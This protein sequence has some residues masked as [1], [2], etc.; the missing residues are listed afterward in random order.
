MSSPILGSRSRA[1][2]KERLDDLENQFI[3]LRQGLLDEL[4]G[5][6]GAG[7]GGGPLQG[8]S[9]IEEYDTIELAQQEHR[10]EK[11]KEDLSADMM[12][13]ID[14]RLKPAL[15]E[16]LMAEQEVLFLKIK[17]DLTVRMKK[18]VENQMS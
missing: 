11:L 7:G 17:D 14:T 8:T 4:K 12:K 16:E 6:V 1:S 3:N 2:I 13:V 5:E 10:T 15:T 18:N 9:K